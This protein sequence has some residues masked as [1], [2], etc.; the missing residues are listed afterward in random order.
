[1]FKSV[2]GLFLRQF[3][4][5]DPLTIIGDGQQIR[6]FTHIEDVIEA[7]ILT[8]ESSLA[9][10]GEVYNV[11][12]GKS[13]SIIE[14]ANSISENILFLPSRPAEVKASMANTAKIRTDYGWFPKKSLID[15]IQEE[16]TKISRY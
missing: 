16:L 2:I 15:Y 7:N 5:G 1:M 12:S 10:T 11:G 6:D 4:E 13:L 14:I 9:G 3:L 8:M